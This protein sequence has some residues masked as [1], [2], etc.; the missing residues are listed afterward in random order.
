M[1]RLAALSI[2]VLALAAGCGEESAG[3]KAFGELSGNDRDA[4]QAMSELDFPRAFI[5]WVRADA[6]GDLPAIR[7]AQDRM[8]DATAEVHDLSI[9]FDNANLRGFLGSYA[10]KLGRLTAVAERYTSY[11]EAAGQR[12]L[13]M[14]GDLVDDLQRATTSVRR[15]D[16]QFIDKVLAEASPEQRTQLRKRLRSFYKQF[17]EAAA[18]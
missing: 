1:K 9:E 8:L 13:A 5:A 17:N 2:A 6:D 18:P 12:D 4:L 7:R 10:D 11:L 16:R 14:E 15:A 3:E